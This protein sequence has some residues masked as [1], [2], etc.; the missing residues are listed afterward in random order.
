MDKKYV[1]Y[2]PAMKNIINKSIAAVVGLQTI[3][4]AL[5]NF[6]A[7]FSLLHCPAIN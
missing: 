1:P 5:I 2:L 7:A 4:Q 3:S 6:T